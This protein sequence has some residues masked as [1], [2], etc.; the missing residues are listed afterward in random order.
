MSLPSPVQIKEANAHLF[1]VHR[2]VAELEQRLEDTEKTA[3]EQAESLIRKDEQLQ[4]A[5]R[6]IAKG[7]DREIVDLQEKL[8]R[9]EELIQRLQNVIKE[10]DDLISQLKHRSQLLNKICKSRPLL[11]NLLSYMAEAERLNALPGSQVD[12]GSPVLDGLLSDTNCRSH[13]V[14][15]NRDF[16][17][18][19]DD[20][21][22]QDL[23]ET[24]FGTTV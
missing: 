1:A 15:N 24:M 8:L 18:S 4:A 16:S 12:A 3:R 22:E 19:D 2:R 17:L 13:R 7:K 20:F 23:D 21:E 11:D 9:S 14:S 10:K 6:E 5:V